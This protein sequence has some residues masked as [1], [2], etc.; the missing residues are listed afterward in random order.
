MIETRLYPGLLLDRDGTIIEDRGCISTPQEISLLPNT[1][2][3]LRLLQPHFRLVLITHQPWVARGVLTDKQVDAIHEELTRLLAVEGVR[4]YGCYY[5]PH[6]R[7]DGCDCV[8]PLPALGL[9]AAAEHELDLSRSWTVGDHPHDVHLA[10]Q[11]G[12]RGGIYVLTGHGQKHRGELEESEHVVVPDLL[13]AAK[14]LL[15]NAGPV[16]GG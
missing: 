7:E 15:C 3:A 4:L 10:G 2:E 12:A 8:K 1:V 5:C 14:W 9:Q 6:T 11:I 16:H 13:A